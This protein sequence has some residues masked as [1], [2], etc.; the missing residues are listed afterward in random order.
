M[1][2][3]VL[4]G[5]AAAMC[6]AQVE[7]RNGW[8]VFGFDLDNASISTAVVGRNFVY[9]NTMAARVN[10]VAYGARTF[11]LDKRSGEIRPIARGAKVMF[12][13]DTVPVPI[14]QCVGDTV[15]AMGDLLAV[16]SLLTRVLAW[17]DGQRWQT[18]S[19]QTPWTSGGS[20][21]AVKIIG[22]T[23]YVT[24][25]FDRV[26]NMPV[27]G[28]GE[29]GALDGAVE[30]VGDIHATAAGAVVGVWDFCFGGGQAAEADCCRRAVS[31]C[32]RR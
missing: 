24:G 14:F 30:C 12:W 15:Y 9:F 32:Q 4:I 8:G 1:W 2:R 16:D 17:W 29:V 26:G 31:G 7:E 25:H 5:W 27:G 19:S 28:D 20:T 3:A 13:L 22:D 11:S 6:L 18:L 23:L 21:S 10:G